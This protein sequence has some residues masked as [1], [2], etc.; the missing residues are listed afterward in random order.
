MP[1]KKGFGAKLEYRTSTGP[2]V[3]VEIANVTKIR[4]FGLKADVIDL[5]SMTSASEF[6]EK[7]AGLKDAGQAAFDMNYDD[8]AVSHIWLQTNIG[9]DGVFKLTGPGTAPKVMTFNG[10][11]QSVGPEIPH[12]NKMTTS[13][14]IEISGLPVWV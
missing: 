11:V 4:P 12:D 1:G 14:V 10:F 13:A 6:R 3:F 5:T 7:T 9:V 2:D 8:K